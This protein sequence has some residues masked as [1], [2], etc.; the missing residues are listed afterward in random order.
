MVSTTKGEEMMTQERM[1]RIKNQD[2]LDNIRLA[3]DEWYAQNEDVPDLPR[4]LE[5]L[6]VAP[7]KNWKQR[8]DQLE[9]DNIRFRE[10]LDLEE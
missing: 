1:I 3:L 7:P 6:E 8:I 9:H 2:Q 5:D 4:N 10:A